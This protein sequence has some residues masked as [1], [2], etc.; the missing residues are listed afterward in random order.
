[1]SYLYGYDLTTEEW[2]NLAEMGTHPKLAGL[3]YSPY[4]D[5]LYGVYGGLGGRAPLRFIQKFTPDGKKAGTVVLSDP[6][7]MPSG[8]HEAVVQVVPASEDR[9]VLIVGPMRNLDLEPQYVQ[10][11]FVVDVKT[12]NLLFRCHQK[13]Q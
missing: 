12:G 7:R 11:A 6:I 8:D 10:T 9:L 1:M 4:E 2:T 5:V 3:A 13:S